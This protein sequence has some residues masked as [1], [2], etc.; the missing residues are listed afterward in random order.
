MFDHPNVLYHTSLDILEEIIPLSKTHGLLRRVRNASESNEEEIE[1]HRR[2]ATPRSENCSDSS[3]PPDELL[4]PNKAVTLPQND[5][6]SCESQ[7]PP[8]A[9]SPA[10]LLTAE[11][12]Y[13]NKEAVPQNDFQN[14][15][16]AESP[17]HRPQQ[18]NCS[19]R[20]KCISQMLS[21]RGS[22]IVMIT[23]PQFSGLFLSV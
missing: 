20:I 4:Y 21:S 5:S 18:G 8:L 14:D 1:K 22:E 16:P 11:M 3:E 7:T 6:D 9:E 12:L 13:A 23:I 17:T 19:T 15:S 2:A 10:P